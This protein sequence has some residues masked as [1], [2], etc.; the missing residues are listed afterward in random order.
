MAPAILSY[1]LLESMETK[2][3]DTNQY[4]NVIVKGLEGNITTE[5]GLLVGDLADQVR[6]SPDLIKA[7]E[8]PDYQTLITRI[9]QLKGNTEF[10]KA[11]S[12]FMLKYGIRAVVGVSDAT[13]K[14]KTGQKIRVDGNAGFVM[15]MDD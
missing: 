9:S 11:F 12:E 5:M 8:N 15:V 4:V 2:L 10:K 6:V 1:R 13:K 3:F 7:F 14:I